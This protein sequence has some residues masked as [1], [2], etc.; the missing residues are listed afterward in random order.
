MSIG[1]NAIPASLGSAGHVLPTS[2]L[3]Q[4]VRLVAVWHER[5]R[6]RRALV[7]LNDHMLK[8]IG[9]TR[10]DALR[11]ASKPFWRL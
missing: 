7:E 8:D 9:I 6:S 4:V 11:E 5:G 2:R 1:T 3:L 10:L